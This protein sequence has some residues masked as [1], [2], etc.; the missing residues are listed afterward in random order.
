V[1]PA[2]GN[3]K[4]Q[5]LTGDKEHTLRGKGPKQERETIINFNEAEP[6]A[7]IWTASEPMCRKLLKLGYKPT[8]ENDRSA[9]FTVP[10]KLVAVR[11]PRRITA[12]HRTRLA[13]KAPLLRSGTVITEAEE[14][15]QG[16]CE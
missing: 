6:S 5:Q 1:D 15:N 12:A 8:E 16:Q 10:K 4:K 3:R 7:S 11:K 14:L 13:D 2:G 9:T